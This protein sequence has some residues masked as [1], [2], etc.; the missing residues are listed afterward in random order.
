MST[1]FDDIKAGLNEAIDY[2]KGETNG[3]VVH[4]ITPVDIKAIRAKV[5]MTQTEFA[6]AV[7]VKLPTLRHW[8][9][10]DR[11]PSGSARVLMNLIARDPKKVIGMICAM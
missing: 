11:R 7:G 10:G 8:E 3:A 4:E 9:R 6:R 1:I 5:G 2:A